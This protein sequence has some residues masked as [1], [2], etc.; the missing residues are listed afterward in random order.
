MAR[1]ALNNLERLDLLELDKG[2]PGLAPEAGA[3]LRH[4]AAICLEFNDHS[5]PVKLLVDGE[6]T[7]PIDLHWSIATDQQRRTWADMQEATEFGACGVAILLIKHLTG[8]IVID[9][10]KKREGGHDYW[11][12]REEDDPY[13]QRKDRLEVSGILSGS[14]TDINARVKQKLAQVESSGLIKGCHI[15]I[16][17]FAKPV[18]RFI[19]KEG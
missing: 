4:C 8:L 16:T 1:Y 18:S 17:E 11:L 5:S 9:R 7:R 6:F 3:C 10:A 2:A 14:E 19:R 12:G 15:I 13:F